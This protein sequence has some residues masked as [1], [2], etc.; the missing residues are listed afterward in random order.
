MRRLVLAVALLLSACAAT[1]VHWRAKS[2]DDNGNAVGDRVSAVPATPLN[3]SYWIDVQKYRDGK[4]YGAPFRLPGEVIFEKDYR[5]WLGVSSPRPGYLYVVNEGPRSAPGRPDYNLLF[6][7]TTAGG[8][9]PPLAAGRE[10]KIPEGGALRFDDQEGT[11]RLWLIYA[12]RPVPEL[13]AVSQTA[14]Q[15]QDIEIRDPAQ[16]RA[17]QEVI[18]RRAPL[19][20]HA[21][22]GGRV[23]SV[24]GES[25]VVVHEIKLEHH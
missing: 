7:P 22:K 21:E 23:T 3:F 16:A 13:D 6:P 25:E 9:A 20:S 24:S 12:A 18:S 11:E 1:L 10:V 19:T 15:K 8:V 5:I 17:V 2:G 14:N 4:P